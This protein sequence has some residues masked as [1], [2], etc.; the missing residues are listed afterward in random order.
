MSFVTLDIK[1]LR[2]KWMKFYLNIMMLQS[3]NEKAKTLLKSIKGDAVL[4]NE[5][6]MAFFEKMEE[7]Q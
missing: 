4:F 7:P 1:E 2:E 6:V 3:H 5:R